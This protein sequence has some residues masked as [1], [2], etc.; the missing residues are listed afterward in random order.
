MYAKGP[1]TISTWGNDESETTKIQIKK[2]KVV[3]N[4]HAGV[5][6]GKSN[7]SICKKVWEG[8]ESTSS[9]SKLLTQATAGRLL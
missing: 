3:V 6:A 1:E 2:L 5:K 8:M 7:L 4:P 9:N